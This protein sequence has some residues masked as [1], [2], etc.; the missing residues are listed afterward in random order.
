M[1]TGAGGFLGR[2]VVERLLAHG[3]TDIR[4][5]L[6]RRANIHKLD[7]LSI[8][9][10][11][12]AIE[13]SI[14]NLK[15]QRDAAVA[16]EDVDLIFHLAA[17]VRGAAADLFQD[18]VVAS[19]NLLEA[20]GTDRK[21]RIVLVSSFAVYGIAGLGRGALVNEQTPLEAHPEWRDS[22]SHAKLQQEQLFW[23]YQ[24]QNGFELV[25]LR[26]G[27]IYGPGSAHISDR[28]GLRIGDWYLRLGGRNHL[29]LTYIENCAEA[30]VIAGAY[31]K[32]AG[33]VFNVLDDDPPTC[34]EYLGA[35]RKVVERIRSIPVPYFGLEVLSELLTKYHTYSRGQ[36]PP[37]LTRYKVASLWGGNRFDNSKLHSIGWKQLVPTNEGLRRS[38]A[39]FRERLHSPTV[40]KPIEAPLKIPK[41]EISYFTKIASGAQSRQ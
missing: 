30:V 36:L 34:R 23:K 8:R 1:V 12:A 39:A 35:Y 13:Y 11:K 40:K 20:L 21:V 10:P 22:Y 7:E 26:P 29:P 16:I 24:R 25:V 41:H 18:S 2:A 37:I 33:Q 15:Y 5:S 6:R 31:K 3:Y 4:C 19:R 9:F 17:G 14:G 38:F 32:A 28:V 27:V